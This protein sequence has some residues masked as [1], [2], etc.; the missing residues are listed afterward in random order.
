MA[1]VHRDGA[2]PR[3]RVAR[4]VPAARGPAR[5]R[6]RRG[7]AR[8]HDPASWRRTR[9]W[10]PTTASTRTRCSP[11]RSCVSAILVPTLRASYDAACWTGLRLAGVRRRV[12]LCGEP[13]EVDAV[14][15]ALHAVGS[16]AILDT[17]AR[18]GDLRTLGA[19]IERR[20]A[21][22]RRARPPAR[23]PHADRRARGVPHEPG[24]PARRPLR[25]GAAG[26]PGDVRRGPRAAAVRGRAADHPGAGLAAQAG[27]RRR[28]RVPAAAAA[29]PAPAGRGARGAADVVR[30]GLLPRPAHGHRRAARSTCSSCAACATAPTA[31]RPSSRP[32]TSATARSS[33]SA[34]TR[35]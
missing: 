8:H 23:R 26:P 18:V 28:R 22:R 9:S 1:A 10:P 31:S 30:A 32:S 33:R 17:V 25:H 5:R 6:Q 3:V 2:V 12:V 24:A 34:T 19:V 35:A 7:G 21:G 14:D 11:S 15:A 29:E 13:H 20:A 4:P 16:G 27:V